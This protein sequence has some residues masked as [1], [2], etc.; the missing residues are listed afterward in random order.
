[1]RKVD[2]PPAGWYPDPQHRQRLR[3]WDGLDWTDIRRAPPSDAELLAAEENA[4]FFE[5]NELVAS[6]RARAGMAPPPPG[7][8]MSRQD[9]EQVI[10]EV[11]NV[12][13]SEVDRAAQDFSSRATTAMRS[14][15][16]LISDYASQLLRWVRRAVIIAIVLLVAYF[17]FQV[18]AQASFLEWLGDRID[19]LD[20]Q[21]GSLTLGGAS[22]LGAIAA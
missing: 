1:M 20:D 2:A 9:V 21:R 22:L 19:S 16:P 12:A 10:A 15:T 6:A 17:L 18:V 14:A 5:S 7:S 8:P 11:R 13:R 3:W 4:A